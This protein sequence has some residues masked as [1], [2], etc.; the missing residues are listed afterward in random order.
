MLSPLVVPDVTDTVTSLKSFPLSIPH[1]L[2]R[3]VSVMVPP[4]EYVDAVHRPEVLV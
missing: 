1:E 3:E 4:L 2:V